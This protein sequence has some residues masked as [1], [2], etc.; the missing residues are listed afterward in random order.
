MD[1]IEK[2]FLNSILEGHC[3]DYQRLNKEVV[4]KV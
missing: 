2:P 1:W 4:A 3:A